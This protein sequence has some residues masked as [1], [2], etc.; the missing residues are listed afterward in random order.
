MMSNETSFFTRTQ[1][2]AAIGAALVALSG[3]AQ[4]VPI[5]VG[6][7]DI[8]LRWDNTVRYNAGWRMEDSN[9]AFYNSAGYDETEGRFKKHDMV[10]NRLDLVTEM[11]LIFKNKYGFRVS[12]AAWSD[13]AYS[14]S[15]V[16]NPALTAGGAY[17][18]DQYNSHTKRYVVGPSGEILDA[19]V[20]GG[21][22]IGESALNV[23]AGK[24]NV[25]WGESL[26]SLTNSIAY[27][28]SAV[29]TIKSASSPGAEAKELFLPRNQ[30]SA[31]AQINGELSMGAHYA[32]A[33]RPFRIVPGGTYFAASDGSRSDYA[34][35]TPLF[36]PNGPDIGPDKQRGDFGLNVRWSPAGLGGTVGVYYRK[37]DEK[38][39]WGVTQLSG[40][41]PT[42]VRLAFARNTEMYGLSLIKTL[43]TASVGAELS[44]RKNTAL[45]SRITA[46]AA[47]GGALSYEEAEGARGN[48]LHGL[49]NG[50]Y[51][52]PETSLWR[53]GTVQGELNYSRLVSVRSNPNRFLAEGYAGCR[54]G[55]DKTDGCSTK[56]AVGMNIAF[57]PQWPQAFPGWD[58]TM[59]NVLAYQILG[60][61]PALGGGNQGTIA[62]STGIVGML[63]SRYEF[64]LK[65]VDARS[66]YKTDPNTGLVTTTNGSNAVQSDHGWLSFTFKTTF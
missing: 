51:L 11:D 52:L 3:A 66:R 8:E 33:W 40:A 14:D 17:V 62:W 59:P 24:H 45:N 58:L 60:N 56:D 9:P 18:N 37:F 50:V 34:A 49:I 23:K 65:Y 19:F 43:N 31:Q 46:S 61:G 41:T 53:G 25:Y 15:S 55:Q 57:N 42:G 7:P 1:V 54:A 32:F 2:A 10:T 16:R 28:Q 36:I 29:D 64:T 26:Y 47:S 6:N 22:D 5:D 13:F 20:F 21:F 4:A 48:T 35:T 30:I 27:S 38:L 12:G 63:Y 44:Y 39:P